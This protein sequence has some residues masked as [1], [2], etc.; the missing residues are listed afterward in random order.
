[1]TDGF[2]HYYKVKE[3]GSKERCGTIPLYGSSVEISNEMPN[4]LAFQIITRMRVYHLYAD[5]ELITKE[6]L[7][8]I[9]QHKVEF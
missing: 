8:A 5:N 7:I 6:W 1:M 3:S 4:Q 9:R 2:L